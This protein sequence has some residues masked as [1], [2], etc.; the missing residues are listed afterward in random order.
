MVSNA[1]YPGH[2]QFRFTSVIAMLIFSPCPRDGKSYFFP[3]E[4]NGILPSGQ[5]ISWKN[6]KETD[7]SVYVFKHASKCIEIVG[8][9]SMTV[10]CLFSRT[11]LCHWFHT[12]TYTPLC[13]YMGLEK[14][15]RETSETQTNVWKFFYW[16]DVKLGYY[17]SPFR[18]FRKKAGFGLYI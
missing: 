12:L 2:K 11:P 10:L 8:G 1:N 15:R 14:K 7:L 5:E 4:L 3:R 13:L 18:E 9:L 16:K 17:F 6:Y